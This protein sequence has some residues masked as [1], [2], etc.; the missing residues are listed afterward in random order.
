MGSP[1]LSA[2]PVQPLNPRPPR[3]NTAADRPDNPAAQQAGAL[4]RLRAVAL[5]PTMARIGIYQAV[6]AVGA[7]GVTALDAFQAVIQRGTPVSFSSVSRLMRELW[8][9]GLFSV[10][11][12]RSGTAVYFLRSE[13]Q[14]ISGIRFECAR[15]DR[16]VVIE[17]ADLH[18]RLLAAARRSGLDLDGQCVVVRG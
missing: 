7:E 17:D 6:A 8:E 15:T 13:D 16:C 9:H 11:F 18:A 4:E 2:A 12:N 3:Q 5:R 10:T 14:A 1:R